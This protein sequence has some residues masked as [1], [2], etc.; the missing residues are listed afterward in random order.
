MSSL[1]HKNYEVKQVNQTTYD[2]VE[3]FHDGSMRLIAYFNT[4]HDAN[5]Y[6]DSLFKRNS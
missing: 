4:E 3:N 5:R 2:V 6:K 1:K